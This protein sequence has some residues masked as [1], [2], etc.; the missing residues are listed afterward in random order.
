MANSSRPSPPINM[1]KIPHRRYSFGNR[2][3]T[4]IYNLI[5]TQKIAKIFLLASLI[6]IL[7]M[8]YIILLT[9]TGFAFCKKLLKVN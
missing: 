5:S 7:N 9:L 6:L 8:D 2:S 4:V 3:T 1:K